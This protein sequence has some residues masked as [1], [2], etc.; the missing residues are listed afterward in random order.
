[1]LHPEIEVKLHDAG[2]ALGA[3]T[4]ENVVE[5]CRQYLA[6]LAAYRAELYKLPDARTPQNRSSASLFYGGER[7][8]GCRDA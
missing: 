6:L 5:L 7:L 8:R 3:A 4:S 1:M 2:L